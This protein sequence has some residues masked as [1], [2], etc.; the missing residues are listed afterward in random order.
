[1]CGGSGNKFLEDKVVVGTTLVEIEQ[2]GKNAIFLIGIGSRKWDF[3]GMD[4]SG[5]LKLNR[6]PA[7]SPIRGKIGFHNTGRYAGVNF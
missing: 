6:Y 3:I 5:V 2:I 7:T 1:V 4:C